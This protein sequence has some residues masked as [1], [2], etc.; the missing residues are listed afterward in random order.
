MEGSCW[1]LYDGGERAFSVF[2]KEGPMAVVGSDAV[3]W[4]SNSY[5]KDALFIYSWYLTN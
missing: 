3:D 5:K 4:L 2:I 1:L